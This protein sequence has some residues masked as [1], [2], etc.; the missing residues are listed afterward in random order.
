MTNK[1]DSLIEKVTVLKKDLEHNSISEQDAQKQ[2]QKII[3]D[4]QLIKD[5]NV[6]NWSSNFFEFLRLPEA[7][8]QIKE[9]FHGYLESNNADSR[10][11][12]SKKLFVS[13]QIQDLLVILN[14]A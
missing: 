13:N 4:Y 7:Q 2:L 9:M 11:D 3:E 8:Q 6:E 1:F 10:K 14:K 5:E 12:R